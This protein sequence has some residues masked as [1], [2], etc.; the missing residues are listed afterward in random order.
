MAGWVT[1]EDTGNCPIAS[2]KYEIKMV[3]FSDPDF[4]PKLVNN[5]W[6]CTQ[7]A[8][9]EQPSQCSGTWATGSSSSQPFTAG[10]RVLECTQMTPFSGSPPGLPAGSNVTSCTLLMADQSASSCRAVCAGIPSSSAATAGCVAADYELPDWKPPSCELYDNVAFPSFDTLPIA[11]KGGTCATDLNG[12]G[13]CSS[14]PPGSVTHPATSHPHYEPWPPICLKPCV[15]RIQYLEVMP[16]G[17]VPYPARFV[18][19]SNRS[20]YCSEVAACDISACDASGVLA[21]TNF[22]AWCRNLNTPLACSNLTSSSACQGMGDCQ[23]TPHSSS[24]GTCQAASS[25][26]GSVAAPP[27]DG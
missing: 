2:E 3:N 15:S 14:Q 16:Q 20:M 27:D 9:H 4:T 6:N 12:V 24:A 8:L 13:C 26:G 10:M 21:H 22:L 17:S 18:S 5:S 25:Q 19:A 7:W 11:P 1:I 23:W